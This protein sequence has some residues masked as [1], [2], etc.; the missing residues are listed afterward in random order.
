MNETEERALKEMHTNMVNWSLAQEQGNW[1]KKGSS[2][3]LDIETYC[4][5]VS[6]YFNRCVLCFCQDV[7]DAWVFYILRY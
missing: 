5:S 6:I 3:Q 4:D 1:M 2:L 7:H